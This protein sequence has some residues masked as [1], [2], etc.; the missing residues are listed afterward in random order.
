M[1]RILTTTSILLGT[2]LMLHVGAMA[3]ELPVPPIPPEDP[4]LAEIAPVPNPDARAPEVAASD[5]PSVDVRLY[6]AKPYDPGLGFAPGSRY[7]TSE[8]RKPIQTPG[9]SISVPL[10]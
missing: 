3:D 5:A 6:R 2:L 8:D 9:V 4:P 10:E 1:T 7:Q